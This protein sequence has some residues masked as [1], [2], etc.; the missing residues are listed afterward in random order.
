MGM[1]RAWARPSFVGSDS[2][3]RSFVT[4]TSPLLARCR[5]AF[6]NLEDTRNLRHARD[7]VNRNLCLLP[8]FSGRGSPKRP[9]TGNLITHIGVRRSASV[10]DLDSSCLL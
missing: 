6:F 1:R 9:C 5:C 8:L 3:V 2:I 7:C 4:L 10:E